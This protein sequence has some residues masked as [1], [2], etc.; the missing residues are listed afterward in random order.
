MED[1]G[2]ATRDQARDQPSS[3]RTAAQVVTGICLLIV[4]V[5][6]VGNTLLL[7]P[8]SYTMYEFEGVAP[9]TRL[10]VVVGAAAIGVAAL[11]AVAAVTLLSSSS[12]LS[13]IRSP[14]LFFAGVAAVVLAILIAG[15]GVS[16][17]DAAA[18]LYV[19]PVAIFVG[20]TGL[21]SLALSIRT[22]KRSA[23]S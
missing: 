7:L 19:F 23:H 12:P 18:L 6:V 8:V 1:P 14:L 10:Y 11:F 20:L 4:A 2:V 5:W 16:A 9:D 21:A 13:R 15:V 22:S 17:G 3:S